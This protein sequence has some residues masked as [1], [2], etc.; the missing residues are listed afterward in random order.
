MTDSDWHYSRA[1]LAKEFMDEFTRYGC[2]A[3]SN[4]S[5]RQVGKTEFLTRDLAP[6]AIH[7]K[8]YPVYVDLWSARSDPARAIANTLKGHALGDKKSGRSGLRKLSLTAGL[9][10]IGA[11]F[12]DLDKERGVHEPADTADRQPFSIAAFGRAIEVRGRAIA[13]N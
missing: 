1:K 9:F 2:R 5:W 12:D 4:F 7:R 6:E 13:V 10:S 8:H 11:K 3:L